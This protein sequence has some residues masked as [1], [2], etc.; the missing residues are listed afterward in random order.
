MSGRPLFG[1][2]LSAAHAEHDTVLKAME[3]RDATKAAKTMR[4]HIVATSAR[5]QKF[6]REQAKNGTGLQAVRG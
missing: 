6:W 5:L 2:T 3:A 1:E 4:Q